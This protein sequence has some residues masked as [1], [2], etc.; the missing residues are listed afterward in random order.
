MITKI[1]SGSAPE[2]EMRAT[3][4]V[5][6]NLEALLPTSSTRGI[7]RQPSKTGLRWRRRGPR[8]D[9]VADEGC[10]RMPGRSHHE[11]VAEGSLVDQIL[12]ITSDTERQRIAGAL[13][14]GAALRLVAD[15]TL[16]LTSASGVAIGLVEADELV[17]R[18]AAGIAPDIGARVALEKGLS[19]ECIR[20]DRMVRLDDS[21]EDVRVDQAVCHALNLRSAM[22]V[23]IR[24]AGS[25]IGVLEVF[26]AKS[27]AFDDGAVL[28]MNQIACFIGEVANATLEPPQMEAVPLLAPSAA[29]PRST[30]PAESS[31]AGPFKLW[32]ISSRH[33]RTALLMV[34]ALA[35]AL[36]AAYRVR[37][38]IRSTPSA[39]SRAE[40]N[41]PV[42]PLFSVGEATSPGPVPTDPA[43]LR[44]DDKPPAT[45]TSA[46]LE[47]AESGRGLE[48][49]TPNPVPVHRTETPSSQLRQQTTEYASVPASKLEI[50]PKPPVLAVVQPAA[51]RDSLI[52]PLM[53]APV[54]DPQLAATQ[55][56]PPGQAKSGK[57][58]F[59][60]R[61]LGK[62]KKLKV[63]LEKGFE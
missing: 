37:K 21:A 27:N 7:P 17:C 34:V 9:R 50:A 61:I 62:P 14:L 11:D 53:N 4:P 3:N 20:S 52:A 63:L 54:A 55:V 25:V 26:S 47:Q 45:A 13:D 1:L 59:M 41:A 28:A 51:Q 23:P 38:T 33:L 32:L 39:P 60:S 42:G 43:I 36:W 8:P 30:V 2:I 6:L 16:T 12:S 29:A 22:V 5:E 49:R 10:R 56:T 57:P 15:R 40:V 44:E 35:I 46:T 24:S 58:S 31:D 48:A 18:A 19:G